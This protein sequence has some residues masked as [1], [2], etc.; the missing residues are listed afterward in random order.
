MFG[1]VCSAI[2]ELIVVDMQDF[3]VIIFSSLTRY[4]TSKRSSAGGYSRVNGSGS[5]RG[6]LIGAF[7]GRRES[8]R[9]GR[10]VDVDAE[11]RL[12]D[13]LDEEWDD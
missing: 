2:L 10:G 7:G 13:Q 12:I 6:G 3:I 8:D 9:A 5:Q 11:N 1:S 4:F